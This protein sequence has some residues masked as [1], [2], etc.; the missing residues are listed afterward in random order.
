VVLTCW[1]WFSQIPFELKE[2]EA[3]F[4]ESYAEYR[5][6]VPKLFPYGKKHKPPK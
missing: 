1:F 3:L 5:R 2:L 6:Q 4:G